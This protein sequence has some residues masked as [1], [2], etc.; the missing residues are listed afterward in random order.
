MDKKALRKAIT[1]QKKAMTE[2]EIDYYVSTG[3]PFGKAGGYAI[4][5]QA[6]R[7]IVGIRGDYF[8]VVGLPV[9]RLLTT[10]KQA[11]GVTL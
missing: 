5:G 10:V 8:N 3:E 4:Q 7:Y 6:P 1:Q 2:Q 11:F 9:H